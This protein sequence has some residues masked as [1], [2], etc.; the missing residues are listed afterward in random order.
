MPNL[1]V[2]NPFDLPTNAVALIVTAGVAFRARTKP[3]DDTEAD[4]GS[5]LAHRIESGTTVW[6][7]AFVTVTV[8]CACVQT[9]MAPII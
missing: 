9:V 3:D 5:P 7:E 2:A 6:P 8:N 4:A 1:I